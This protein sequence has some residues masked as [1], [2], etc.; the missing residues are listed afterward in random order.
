MQADSP[1][2]IHRL[3]VRTAL[4]AS[5]IFAWI[6]IFVFF[7][8]AS[9]DIAA[10]LAH[11]VLL[12]ALSQT[13]A[14]LL[15]PLT[16]RSLRQGAQRMM[17][18]GVILLALAMVLLAESFRGMFG[19]G[20]TLALIT[21]AIAFGIHRAL[22]WVPYETQQ[23]RSHSSTWH[24]YAEVLLALIPA[25]IGFLLVTYRI[26]ESS[27]LLA[28]AGAMLLSIIPLFRMQDSY[29][30][31]AWGYR[32][33]FGQLFARPHRQLFFSAFL[34]GIQGVTLLLLWPLAVFLVVGWSYALL[35]LLFSFSLLV[36]I[37]LKSTMDRRMVRPSMLDSLPVRIAVVSS[38]WVGRIFIFNPLSIIVA[39]SYLHSGRVRNNID[40]LTFEQSSDG[41]HYIDE[42]TVLREV[43][44]MLGRMAMC[45]IFAISVFSLSISLTFA[46]VF[47]LAALSAG[48]SVILSA[49]MERNI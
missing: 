9:G 4:S 2:S 23:H 30:G 48:I 39:D 37:L 45:M 35:G 34:D 26:S 5:N 7:F 20:T 31:F 29:E 28:A 25:F 36:F 6:F 32:E 22:Y 46:V 21:V 33:T 3:I 24:S 13:I 14:C 49:T 1:L 27:L 38:S 41:S 18:L 47:I 19:A 12:Y 8:D 15:T 43:G 10:S 42:Y 16:A 11:T 40:H 44:L 17:V